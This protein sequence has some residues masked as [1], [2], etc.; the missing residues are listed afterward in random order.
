M[1][2][3]SKRLSDNIIQWDKIGVPDEVKNWIL[4]GT[5]IDFNE[6]GEPAPFEFKNPKF[7]K[8][9]FEFM[10]SEITKLAKDGVIQRVNYKPKYIS[11]VK[12]VPK[13]RNIYQEKESDP[14]RLIIDLFH[15]NQHCKVPKFQYDGFKK[16]ASVIQK[17]DYFTSFDLKKG[18]YHIPLAKDTSQYFG[19]YFHGHYYIWLVCPFGWACSPYY[20]HKTL[21]VVK[22]YLNLNDIRSTI[23]VD[24]SLVAAAAS[25]ITDHTDFAIHTFEDLGFSINYD[26]SCL[27]ATKI[28]AYAGYIYNSCGPNGLPWVSVSEDKI[29]KLIRD[30]KRCLKSGKMHARFLAKICGQGIAMSRVILP[31][32]FKLWPLYV[33]LASRKSWNDSL[34]ITDPVRDCLLWW[35]NAAKSWNGSPLHPRPISAQVTTDSSSYGWGAHFEELEAAGSWDKITAGDHIN[36]KEL[37]T[38]LNAILCF[39]ERLKGQSVQF[40]SDSITAVAYLNNMGGPVPRLTA[41][42]ES[43]WE[44]AH[45]LGISVQA[46][47]LAGRLNC[48]ADRLSRLSPQYEWS[49]C[50][51]LFRFIDRLYGPHTVD[52]FASQA[53]AMLPRYNSR[54]LDPL[55][56]G[57]DALAQQDWGE[58]VNFVNPPFRLLN[59]VIEVIISQKAH[60]TIIAPM[61]ADHR[62]YRRMSSIL[63]SPPLRLRLHP[64]SIIQYGATA[65]PLRNRRWKIYA[66]RVFGGRI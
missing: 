57:V 47:F 66:W 13:K 17:D 12:C 25:Q 19:F 31:A 6:K 28:I 54:Y 24:D 22:H 7:R 43:I 64:R 23:Y 44:V 5:P 3:M 50:P 26:K 48:Q 9:E 55:T 18:F 62:W 27:D 8:P 32:K 46:S 33:L 53:T 49:L 4:H 14:F 63:I 42:A 30:I 65:E 16:V 52:R 51:S 60:A 21:R 59:Q 37:Y 2:C 10:Q 40:V 15:F 36:F 1:V 39:K 29:N 58:E 11:A 20:F 61:W 38:V 34:F 45:R 35:I 56:S 41:L